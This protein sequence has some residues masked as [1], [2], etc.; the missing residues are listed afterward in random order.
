MRKKTR[1]ELRREMRRKRRE[2][3]T[4]QQNN[5][6]TAVKR[7]VLR[8]GLLNSCTSTAIYF[9]FNGELD[10]Q[11]LI[12]ALHSMG[13]T[14]SLPVIKPANTMEFR[15]PNVESELSDNRYGIPEPNPDT[16]SL[17]PLWTHS[18]IF[19]PLLAFDDQGNRIG[20][21]GGYYDRALSTVRNR[22]L[23]IGLAHDLQYSRAIPTQPWD[24]TMDAVI[25]EKVVW[26]FS[27]RA[28]LA[29]NTKVHQ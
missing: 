15:V 16:S 20:M 10:T 3:S 11:P 8:S 22:P 24:E 26:A 18:V 7:Q 5:H 25:T 1:K 13:K 17:R 28:A 23:C 4:I 29:L 21:G 12:L 14:V 9:S 2:L 27:Q 19:M 6:A